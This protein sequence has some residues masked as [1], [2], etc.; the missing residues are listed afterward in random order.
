MINL[1]PPKQKEDLRK[2]RQLKIAL[3]LGLI[4]SAV[5]ISQALL[6]F[7]I[8]NHLAAG[9][10]IQ[11][12]YSRERAEELKAPAFKELEDKI[13][14]SGLVFV[15][16]DSFYRAEGKTGA[17]G[18][19]EKIPIVLVKGI[20]LTSLDFDL[21]SRQVSLAG[22]APTREKLLNLRENLEK[23]KTFD[24]I[25]FPPENWLSPADINFSAT[26][27]TK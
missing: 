10:E 21:K 20:Y 27:K 17:V 1:L 26:F 23:E 24:D 14:S 3:I 22:F 25:Y 7:L 5:F 15:N 16:L 12:I 18:L 4:L 13:K 2:E 19:L 6:L 8:K 9:L 11:K